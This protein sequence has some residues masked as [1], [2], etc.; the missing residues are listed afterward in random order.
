[1]HTCALWCRQATFLAH[2]QHFLQA[3]NTHYR[4]ATL[5]T[6]RRVPLEEEVPTFSYKYDDAA[7]HQRLQSGC[8]N[9][10]RRRFLEPSGMTFDPPHHK[11]KTREN[12]PA[13]STQPTFVAVLPHEVCQGRHLRGKASTDVG[14]EVPQN[15][16]IL[17]A[18]G[19]PIVQEGVHVDYYTRQDLP[20]TC[21]HTPA[22]IRTRASQANKTASH[23][24]V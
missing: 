20:C 8:K 21:T 6:D 2:R 22:Q 14:T 10:T 24:V 18:H 12:N 16:S 17:L 19:R 3:G 13:T 4:Q 9:T 1:M 23:D 15:P 5:L 7:A 11:G